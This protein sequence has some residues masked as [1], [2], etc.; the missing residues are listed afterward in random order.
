M[1][2]FYIV[3]VFALLINLSAATASTRDSIGVE[4]YNGK[5]LIV[6]QVVAKDTYYSIGRRYH[7]VP[8]VVM[9]F[10]D[11]KFLQVGV[12]IKVPT[13]LPFTANAV[14]G[15]AN[16]PAITNTA[17]DQLIEHTV[18]KKENLNM[19]AEKYGTTV[20]EIKRVNNLNS[21]NLQIGQI[22]KIPAKSGRS[23]G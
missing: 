19:L 21:I 5:K 8:K 9:N 2:K 20:N 13:N 11:S 10:N 1:H 7:V 16:Q 15:K 4:N 12:I 22:L 6:H 18:Q 17:N 14:P 3:P 23:T